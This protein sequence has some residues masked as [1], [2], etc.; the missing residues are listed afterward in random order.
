MPAPVARLR[1]EKRIYRAGG[2]PM[3]EAAIDRGLTRDVYLSMGE[4]LADGAWAVRVHIK[5]YVN[6]IWLGCVLMAAGGFLAASDRRYRRASRAAE[7]RLA[8]GAGT[9]A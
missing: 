9:A 6:W 8:A 3:T 4:P 7:T 5:P 1:P 2:Q